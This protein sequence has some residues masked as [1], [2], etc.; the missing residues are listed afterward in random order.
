[1]EPKQSKEI[2]AI[3]KHDGRSDS[4]RKALELCNGLDGLKANDK[5]LLKPNILWGGTRAFP[6]FG[7]V[8]TSTM[9]EYLL[10]ILRDRGCTDITI[11]EGTILNKEMGSNTMRGYEWLGIG[12]VAKRYG[13]KLVDFNSG[14]YEEVQLENVRAKISKSVMECD[15]L[16]DLPVLKAHA[17]TKI[18]L[19]MK[20][21]K[22]CLAQSSKQTFH[23]HSL[24]L[25][26]LIALLNM[27]IR[28]SLTVI[29]GIYGLERG[30]DFVG[31]I[32][33]RMDLIIAGKDVFSCDIVGAMVMGIQP[34]GV[35]HLKEFASLTGRTISLDK[36]EVSGEPINQVAKK[37]EWRR[38][39]E[40]ILRQT[41]ITGVT[42]Q[43]PG[44]SLCSGCMIIIG[45]LVSVLAKDSPG[46]V[47]DRLEICGG[48]EVKAKEE[49]KKVFLIG[50]CAILANK[51]LKDAVMVK[52]CPPPIMD[53]VM[54]V[55]RKGLPQQKAFVI[56]TSRMFKGIGTK[57]G[58]YDE[59][60][61]AFG[62][63]KPPEFDRKHF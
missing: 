3:V 54:A 59:T 5:V 22:G 60:F 55:V 31:T 16:I 11:G 26:R 30:P 35:E 62:V 45:A 42:I 18:S 6:P 27:R 51:D 48:R 41:G 44:L 10:Q 36:V 39:M 12:K 53:T 17:Q 56:L 15:F 63:C 57:L 49:S 14:P 38:S 28:P 24:G 47:L 29:D 61:P 46:V 58:V 34:D 40:D 21:L 43:D 2:V 25:N 20:N 37:F 8:T 4:L 13:V 50:D 7:R 19:G 9:V 23:R 32:P 33:H 52:G 1:M